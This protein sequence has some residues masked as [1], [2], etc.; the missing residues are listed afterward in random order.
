MSRSADVLYMDGYLWNV[1]V[2]PDVAQWPGPMIHSST[3]HALTARDDA[4]ELN[5]CRRRAPTALRL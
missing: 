2:S 5:T 4:A 3:L 1:F